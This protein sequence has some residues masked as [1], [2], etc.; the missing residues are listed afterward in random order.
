MVGKTSIRDKLWNVVSISNRVRAGSLISV[1]DSK[2]VTI[3][4]MLVSAIRSRFTHQNTAWCV[5]GS[6]M[7]HG[8]YLTRRCDLSQLLTS[9]VTWL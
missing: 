6:Y 2:C 5:P 8:K 9:A 4:V 3:L 7:L 1:N